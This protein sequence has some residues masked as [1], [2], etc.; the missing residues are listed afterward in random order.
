MA[1]HPSAE[2]GAVLLMAVPQSLRLE[3]R[4]VHRQR[5][6]GLARLALETEVEDVVKSLVA[7]RR[8]R[9]GRRERVYE[10]IRAAARRMLL[11]PRCHERRTHRPTRNLGLATRSDP[12]ATIRRVSHSA[13]ERKARRD[14]QRSRQRRLAEMLGHPRRVDLFS[15]IEPAAWIE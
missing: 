9:V 2:R 4:H 14:W 1:E 10:R 5:T 15:G 13:V 7:E 3:R 11:I 8:V 6:L 12:R